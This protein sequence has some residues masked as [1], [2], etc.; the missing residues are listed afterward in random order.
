MQDVTVV[1]KE[2]DRWKEEVRVQEAK[3]CVASSRLKAEIEAHR[4]TRD[5]LDKTI[6]HLSETRQEVSCKRYLLSWLPITTGILL[7]V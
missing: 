6:Q 1:K 5:Q 7:H 3:S 4:E 2:V